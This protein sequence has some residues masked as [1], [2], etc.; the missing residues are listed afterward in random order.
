MTGDRYRCRSGVND[1]GRWGELAGSATKGGVSGDIGWSAEPD[2]A[3]SSQG[4][5]IAWTDTRNGNHEVY[6]G[7][8]DGSQW[9]ELAGS[10]GLGGI[11]DSDT[12]SSQPAIATDANGRPIVAWTESTSAG[13]D[14]LVAYYDAS[15]GGGNGAWLPLAGSNDPGGLSQSSN[16]SNAQLLQTAFGTMVAWI[17]SVAGTP[18]VY[19]KFFDGTAWNELAGSASAGGITQVQ[20]GTHVRD[21]AIAEDGTSL[22]VAWTAVDSAGVRQVY[23]REFD[24]AAWGESQAPATA[25]VSAAV[26]G[27]LPAPGSNHTTPTLAYHGGSLWASW[28]AS[29]DN[30]QAL[31]T[32]E[33]DGQVDQP[34]LRQTRTE[35]GELRDVQLA[36]SGGELWQTLLVDGFSESS[37]RL[38]ATRWDGTA[39]TGQQLADDQ[40]L[41][42]HPQVTSAASLSAAVDANGQLHLAWQDTSSEVAEV[43]LRSNTHPSGTTFYAS[44]S[45]GAKVQ[46][47][48]DSNDLSPGDVIV[49]TESLTSDINIAGDDAGVLLIGD[50]GTQVTG[51]VSINADQIVLQRL[52]I[53]G[54]VSFTETNQSALR[55]SVIY[56]S[57]NVDSGSGIQITGNTIIADGG[58]AVVLT[59]DTNSLHFR[60]NRVSDSAI[61]IAFGDP[62]LTLAG[63][64]IDATIRD[65]R[66]SNNGF[67]IWLG[68]NAS[69]Q[70]FNNEVSGAATALSVMQPFTGAIHS[71]QFHQSQIG[72]QYDAAAEIGNNEVF[73]NQVGVVSTVDSLTDG[74]GFVGTLLGNTILAN[75]VGLQSSGRVVRQTIRGNDIGVSGSGILGGE[76]LDDANIIV[77]NTTG[78]AGFDGTLQF[79]VISQ[80]HD[81]RQCT[82]KS[83]NCAQRRVEKY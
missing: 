34:H 6:V 53:I 61:G 77:E 47:I 81:R 62:T 75:E 26:S 21:L 51:N 33:Y 63:S 8:N 10:A 64:A 35:F 55:D 30:G 54:D 72:I 69:G 14:V 79:N 20:A 50:P 27:S 19:A 68:E 66:L 49:V 59:G 11:T 25:G 83:T 65:N 67:G 73:S 3:L 46:D 58:H 48:L 15:A 44:D 38:Y 57:V 5:L 78:I 7:L 70:I 29:S 17:E 41:G 12:R 37:S 80:N 31:V 43:F 1:L 9:Q 42:V 32:V 2:L 56:G 36:A 4:T 16:A 76:S 28:V 82:V 39:L 13:T 74:L 60:S 22:A 45:P 71:N 18:Q 40:Q 52:E 23:L 24:G